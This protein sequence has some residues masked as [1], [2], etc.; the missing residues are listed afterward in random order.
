MSEFRRFNPLHIKVW[1]M[2]EYS[3]RLYKI[4]LRT[5]MVGIES[6]HYLCG[7]TTA[8]RYIP[9]LKEAFS[10]LLYNNFLSGGNDTLLYI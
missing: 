5:R 3:S 7:N 2:S 6:L 8:E 9:R 1:A 4:E 10:F